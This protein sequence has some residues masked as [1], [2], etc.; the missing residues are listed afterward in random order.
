VVFVLKY[1]GMSDK[2]FQPQENEDVISSEIKSGLS[3]DKI[4][5]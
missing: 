5:L 1:I 4:S 2:S 3:M